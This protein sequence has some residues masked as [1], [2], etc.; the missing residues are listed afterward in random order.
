[1]FEV[2][3]DKEIVWEHTGSSNTFRAQKYGMGY[4][5]LLGDVNGDGLQDYFL[6]NFSE[7][8]DTLFFGEGDGFFDDNTLRSGLGKPTFDPLGFG[9]RLFD[10]DLDGDLDI[11]VTRGHILDNL[12]ALHPGTR[13]RYAQPDH[14]FQNDG[15]GR[16]TDVSESSGSW[17]KK[18]LVG[19]AV[20]TADI[21]MDDITFCDGV[22]SYL[23]KLE[24]DDARANLEILRVELE[25]TRRDLLETT[26]LLPDAEIP[27]QL[28]P[29]PGLMPALPQPD[30]R[31]MLLHPQIVSAL[32][33]HEAAEA[34]LQFEI[35]SQYP[36]ISI[37]PEF[38]SDKGDA[39]LGAGA[40]IELPLFERNQ[41]GIAEAAQRREATREKVS[42]ALLK[43]THAEAKARAEFQA[44][45]TILRNYSA[46]A[47]A[48]ALEARRALDLRLQAGQSNVLEVLA[49]L[50]SI[51]SARVRELRLKQ[52]SAIACFSAATA[53]AIV[54]DDPSNKD[55]EKEKK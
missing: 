8:T 33:E 25:S 55:S 47:M 14:L 18:K 6:T 13:L 35:S 5:S 21:V 1:M 24:R 49:G 27:I 53:G 32:S 19:R 54:L 16:F 40:G 10:Y 22:T 46:G 38:E 41:G 11:Y 52:E 44:K 2:T 31:R 17:F 28:D 39:S 50:R 30:R 23:A 43:L 42:N 51:T 3:Y 48:S 7:E 12:E 9:T 36:A 4:F 37:G 26:G 29:E 45:E 34:A 15:K 20:A